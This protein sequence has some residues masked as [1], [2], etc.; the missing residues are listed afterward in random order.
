[1]IAVLFSNKAVTAN[2]LFRY[3]FQGFDRI[4]AAGQRTIHS[5][6]DGRR[7]AVTGERLS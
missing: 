2:P 6:I 5:S 1:V 3:A 7:L 4:K